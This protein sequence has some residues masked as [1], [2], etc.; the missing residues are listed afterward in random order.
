MQLQRASTRG[1]GC[2][3]HAQKTPKIKNYIY[4]TMKKSCIYTIHILY[5]CLCVCFNISYIVRLHTVHIH[6]STSLRLGIF[7]VC[8]VRCGYKV[9]VDAVTKANMYNGADFVKG[10][11]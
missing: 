4:N 6:P 1:E 9:D 7:Q 10:H 5:T 2:K 3:K 8:L 11:A